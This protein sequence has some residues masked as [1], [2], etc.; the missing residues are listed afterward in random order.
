MKQI[1]SVLV[2]LCAAGLTVPAMA[3]SSTSAKHP[4]AAASV[5]TMAMHS[6]KASTSAAQSKTSA[7]HQATTHHASA[8]MHHSKKESKKG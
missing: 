5:S 2:I 8:T 1:L 4:K 3:N 6:N 7:T